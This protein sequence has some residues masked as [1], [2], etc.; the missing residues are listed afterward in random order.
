[1]KKIIL[2]AMLCLIPLTATSAEEGD[3][4]NAEQDRMDEEELSKFKPKCYVPIGT[5]REYPE[6][7]AA[8]QKCLDRDRPK[9]QRSVDNSAETEAEPTESPEE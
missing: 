4:R 2:F 8:F 9:F 5:A 1:M 7:W 3:Y 6:A